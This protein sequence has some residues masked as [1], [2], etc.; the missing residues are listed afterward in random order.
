MLP[1]RS[2]ACTYPLAYA[3]QRKQHQLLCSDNQHL[4]A[5]TGAVQQDS[6]VSASEAPWDALDCNSSPSMHLGLGCSALP[7]FDYPEDSHAGLGSQA[8]ARPLYDR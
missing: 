2:P 8:A 6:D 7:D 3:D 4:L 1:L 5:G